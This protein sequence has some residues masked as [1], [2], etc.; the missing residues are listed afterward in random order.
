MADTEQAERPRATKGNPN[1]Y[2]GMPS[3][4]PTGKPR[5]AID[6]L[7]RAQVDAAVGD[8]PS[9]L[10]FMLAIMRR[11]EAKLKAWKVSLTYVTPNM[12][13]R[14]A[15]SAIQ[16]TNRK[17]PMAIDGGPGKPISILTPDVLSKL[18]DEELAK[19]AAVMTVLK[20][21]TDAANAQNA[22][23]EART[24]NGEADAWAAIEYAA[25]QAE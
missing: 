14:A 1:F 18:S 22:Q 21:A 11:D 16:Y 20:A 23:N 6:Y 15:E 9:P 3:P 13:L 8:G 5:G 19:L 24:I 4:N 25:R 12:R 7:T 10:D 17:Q 2:K